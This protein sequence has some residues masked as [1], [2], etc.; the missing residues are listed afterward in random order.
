M[1]L[2]MDL[3]AHKMNKLSKKP[4]LAIVSTVP[5]TVYSI[6]KG[7][8]RWL[9]DYF[10]VI[11]ISSSGELLKK[12]GQ[13][14][15][16]DVFA[17][18]MHR[19]INIFKDIKSVMKMYFL[20][21]EIKPDIVHS[22][23]PKAGMV[24]MLSSYLSGVKLRVHTFTGLIF[25]SRTG[26]MRWLLKKIDSLICACATNVVPEGEGVK[27]QLITNGVTDKPLNVIGNGNIAGVD[28]GYFKP[29]DK[30]VESTPYKSEYFTFGFIGRLNR[31]KGIKELVEAFRSFPSKSKLLVAGGWD[32]TNPIDQ[33][34]KEFL[35]NHS[36]VE[37]LGF[38]EDVREVLSR[39]DIL[40]LP[41]Y[42]EGFPN[43]VLQAGAMAIPSIVTDIPG[44]TDI[45]FDEFNG[46]IVKPKDSIALCDAMLKAYQTSPE[47]LKM[48]GSNARQ[49]VVERFDQVLYRRSLLEFYNNLLNV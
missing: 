21:R 38:V 18:E 25:P 28:I 16:V 2:L 35:L 32:T 20:L 7:Q 39:L 10:Q 17:I 5:D 26:F 12:V 6:L 30:N 43:I 27:N 31:D 29:S 46:W 1:T 37:V 45:I 23:T 19:G 14:E 22:Y 15:K 34:D 48:I 33:S 9:S 11:I 49:L 41:S 13:N 47:N 3:L 4:K 36:D 24:A 42:R 44:S 8:P 40:I